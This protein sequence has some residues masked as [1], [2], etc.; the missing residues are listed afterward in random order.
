MTTPTVSRRP[1]LSGS[2]P[3][4]DNI[5]MI[6]TAAR[7]G[8]TR[9][10]RRPWPVFLVNDRVNPEARPLI[11]YLIAEGLLYVVHPNQPVSEV[12][13]TPTGLAKIGASA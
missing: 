4:A 12:L 8:L 1:R 7:R 10:I 5:Q 9:E 3:R 2:R 6:A 11:T 13:P